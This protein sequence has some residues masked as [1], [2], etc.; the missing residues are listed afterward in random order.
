MR[1]NFEGT[2]MKNYNSY[3]GGITLGIYSIFIFSLYYAITISNGD[4]FEKLVPFIPTLSGKGIFS[5]LGSITI[6]GIWGF[7]LG[8][9]FIFFY[10][11]FDKKFK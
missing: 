2:N 11:Y 10:N 7:F 1:D 4:S 9:T 8:F 3:F 6:A 5:F